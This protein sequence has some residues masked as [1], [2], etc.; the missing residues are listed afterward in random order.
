MGIGLSLTPQLLADM[1]PIGTVTEI[2]VRIVGILALVLCIY[3]YTA[4]R[5]NSVWFARASWI[6]RYVFCAGLALAGYF[7]DLPVIIGLAV[8]EALLA[9]WTLWSL[10]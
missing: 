2:W 1:L 4:I 10:K 7:Y 9:T 5:Q 6:G 3:Y 8:L